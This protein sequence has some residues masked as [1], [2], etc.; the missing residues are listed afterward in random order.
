MNPFFFGWK[1]IKHKFALSYPRFNLL[2]PYSCQVQKIDFLII[3]AQKSGTSS[4]MRFLER[5]TEYFFVANQECH[6]WSREAK[7]NK[8]DGFAEYLANFSQAL[9]NQIVGEKS[10]SYLATDGTAARIAKHYPKIKIIA[11]LRNPADRAYS[12]YLHGQRNGA[13]SKSMSFGE[14]IRNYKELKGVP[15]GDVISQGFY[16]KNLK[17]YYEE[18]TPE[19]IL[20]IDFAEMVSNPNKV[21]KE[22]LEFLLPAETV[23]NMDLALVLP[24]V[25]VARASKYPRFVRWVR[26]RKYLST[27][28]K[29]RISSKTFTKIPDSKMELADREYLDELFKESK[30]DLEQLTGKS[31]QWSNN[32]DS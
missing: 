32:G 4:L 9:P 19:Q 26:S 10:P 21:L 7:Y 23:Q 18:F 29:Y 14:A 12:A 11:I 16:A 1:Q 3:G 24:N 25:N 20:I 17:S 2:R 15:Y 13:L 6:F 28:L 8:P 27:S 22:V 30:Q 31:F 5:N